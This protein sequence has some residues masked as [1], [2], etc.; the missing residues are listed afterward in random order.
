MH[1]PDLLLPLVGILVAARLAGALSRRLGMPAVLGELLAGLILGPSVLG[2]IRSDALLGG[3]ADLGVLVL[4][5]IAGLE[6]DLVQMRR[7]GTAS[8]ATAIGGVKILPFGEN[9]LLTLVRLVAFFPVAILSG[10]LVI[11]PLLR[12]LSRGHEKETGLALVL[13]VV[14]LY[15]WAAEALRRNTRR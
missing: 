9:V 10:K 13:A 15:A 1:S 3:F 4:I 5:F 11:S 14:F 2:V 7:V 8:T 6:T 12:R